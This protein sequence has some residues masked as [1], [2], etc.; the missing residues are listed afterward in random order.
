[1]S[2][3]WGTHQFHYADDNPEKEAEIRKLSESKEYIQEKT[4]L[5]S[6]YNCTYSYG[7]GSARVDAFIPI[8]IE[9]ELSCI[10]TLKQIGL[11]DCMFYFDERDIKFYFFEGYRTGVTYDRNFIWYI[12]NE[13]IAIKLPNN[14]FL[15]DPETAEQLSIIFDDLYDEFH[16]RRDSLL[17][18]LGATYFQE[19]DREKF[20]ILRV[21]R[22][23][24]I[25]MVDFAQQHDHYIGNTEW[26]IFHPLNLIEK[27]HIIIYNNHL[28]VYEAD[29]LAEL[30]VK[31]MS[32]SY[33]DILW[34]AGH[35]PSLRKMEGFDNKIKWKADY[36]HDWI[37]EN[38]IPYL[39]YLA[40]PDKR[41]IFQRVC[42]KKL[43]FEEFKSDFDC[44][45][46]GIQSLMFN[47]QAELI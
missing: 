37:L 26:D 20:S 6:S 42:K 16:K 14:R 18:T 5:E 44:Q 39:F 40:F 45:K 22:N 47:D 24:W 34:K 33:V 31:D 32:G 41:N 11:S 19:I 25:A 10:I 9:Q 12:E 13:N 17:N 4:I 21:P 28:N 38:F 29:I 36:T 15:S 46:V 8:S 7:L 27:N 3:Y 30:Y 35:T 43:G 2:T 23:I 1:M